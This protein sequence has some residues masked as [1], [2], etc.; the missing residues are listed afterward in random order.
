MVFAE[1]VFIGGR[2]VYVGIFWLWVASFSISSSVSLSAS[3]VGDSHSMDSKRL[4]VTSAVSHNFVL[5][6]AVAE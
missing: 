6:L 4:L 5:Y 1:S 2:L 3:E